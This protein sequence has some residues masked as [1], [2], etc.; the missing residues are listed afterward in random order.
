MCFE[1]IYSELV[2]TCVEEAEWG[3]GI[4]CVRDLSCLGYDPISQWL[5]PVC[6]IRAESDYWRSSL[7]FNFKIID[8]DPNDHAITAGMVFVYLSSVKNCFIG[9][10]FVL[11]LF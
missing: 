11:F 2:V 3:V 6:D 9:A 4:G 5:Q 8:N 7:N 1:Q 10:V